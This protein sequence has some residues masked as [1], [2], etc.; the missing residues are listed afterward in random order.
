MGRP[1]IEFIQSQVLPWRK[2]LYGGAR[3]DVHHKILSIDKKGLDSSLLVRYPEKWKRTKGEHLLVDEEIYVLDGELTINDHVYKKDTYAHFP[4]GYLRRKASA[5]NGAVVLTFYSGKPKAV[6][7]KPEDKNFFDPKRLVEYHNIYDVA[8]SQKHKR[9]KKSKFNSSGISIQIL[10]T[11][12]YTEERTWIFGSAGFWE[13]GNVEIHPVVEES[14][15]L[16]GSMV[17]TY[18]ER[19]PGG[20][21]WRPPGLEHGPLGSSMGCFMFFRSIGG[22]LTTKFIDKGT[23]SWYPKYKPALPK[24]LRKYAK[25]PYVGNN[26]Y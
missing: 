21:F 19:K 3:P 23:Y 6:A 10:R 26:T 2:G 4:A 12:P 17:G 8:W 5:K 25:K 14:Y 20:Y 16:S 11:D 7:E 9:N 22:P 24:E 13:G 15:M 18:G 1:H